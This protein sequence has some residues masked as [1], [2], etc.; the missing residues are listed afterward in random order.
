MVN[1]IVNN[2]VKFSS[3]H[4]YQN[5][6]SIIN[7][8]EN[9]IIRL[10]KRITELHYENKKVAFPMHDGIILVHINNI[11]YLEAK[12][13]YTIIHTIE[14]KQILISKTLKTLEPLFSQ[15]VFLRIHRSY[16]VNNK[17]II[18][19]KKQLSTTILLENKVEL[20]VS[21]NKKNFVNQWFSI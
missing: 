8:L 16:L 12:S 1:P 21:R 11:I 14:N 20:P 10:E 7:N 17:Y 13:N 3:R 5:K 4:E 6:N 19:I 2:I 9:K 18:K 15:D